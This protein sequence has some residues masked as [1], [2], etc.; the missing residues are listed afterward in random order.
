MGKPSN[1]F[2]RFYLQLDGCWKL[3]RREKVGSS[4][5]NWHVADFYDGDAER[6][7]LGEAVCNWLNA[8]LSD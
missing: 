7:L 4:E 8:N 2:W 1:Q 6:S 3:F 5:E